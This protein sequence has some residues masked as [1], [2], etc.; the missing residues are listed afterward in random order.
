[1]R[2]VEVL[3]GRFVAQA[4]F[5][6]QTLDAGSAGQRL[7]LVDRGGEQVEQPGHVQDLADDRLRVADPHPASGLDRGVADRRDHRGGTCHAADD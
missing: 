6:V 4:A 2:I 1:M 7:R 5:G 3:L